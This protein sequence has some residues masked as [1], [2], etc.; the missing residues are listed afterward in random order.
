[1]ASEKVVDYLKAYLIPAKVY[2]TP[3]HPSVLLMCKIFV[4]ILYAHG[5]YA[6]IADPYIPFLRSLDALNSYPGIFEYTLKTT[7]L[8]TSVLLLFNFK[9][10]TNAI[11]MAIIVFIAILA[12]KPIFRNHLFIIGCALLLA[13]LSNNKDKPWLLYYQLSLVYVGALLNKVM[14]VDWWTGQF[15]HNW[16]SNA[17]G[18]TMYDSVA[19]ALPE[20]FL[21]KVL[22]YSA[23]LAELIIAICLVIPRLRFYGICVILIFHTLLFT[24]TGETFGYFM[25]DILVLLIAFSLWPK[26]RF[27][28]SYKPTAFSG[29][30]TKVIQLFDF[31]NRIHIEASKEQTSN[32]NATIEGNIYTN[33]LAV[34]RVLLHT[35]G[36]YFLILFIEMMIRYVFNDTPKYIA[37]LILFWVLL[38]ALAPILFHK[39]KM[40]KQNRINTIDHELS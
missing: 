3:M 10:R 23:M 24:F 14:Q 21:A 2:G 35:S 27:T 7:F 16:L 20:M 13:G 36:F 25:E 33:W 30:L 32:Y 11:I 9:V 8:I 12:S 38:I 26:E 39:L 19:S 18:N 17:L 15:M 4:V 40:R 37:L 34:I 31:D 1:M 22:A 6:S 5:F 28:L 29:V